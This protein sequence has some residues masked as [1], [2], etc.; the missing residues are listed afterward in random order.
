MADTGI[1]ATKAEVLR[2]A[3]DGASATSIAEAYT[4]DFMTQ[5]ES[6]INVMTRKNWSDLYTGL[7]TD[8]KAILKETASNLAAI[9]VINFDMSGYT[10][11]TEA[12]NM[13]NI[14]RDVA[15]RNISILRDLKQQDFMNGA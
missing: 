9:Y 1:F 12:A 11:L 6:T 14:L 3:G 5:A 10:N 13:I 4:N 2:K 15:L 8:V 7:N